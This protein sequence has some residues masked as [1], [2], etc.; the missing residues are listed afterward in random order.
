MRGHDGLEGHIVVVGNEANL[1]VWSVPSED[2]AIR[3]VP[4]RRYVLKRGKIVAETPPQ[5][6]KVLG[7]EIKFLR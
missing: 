5:S 4:P 2:D 7:E 6:T 3:T 1:I